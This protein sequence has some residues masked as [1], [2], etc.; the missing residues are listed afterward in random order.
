MA[1]KTVQQWLVGISSGVMLILAGPGSAP[2]QAN[3]TLNGTLLAT[4]SCEAVQSIK[5]QTN[6]GKIRLKAWE[7]YRVIGQNL[8]V[9]ATH[10][11]L[12][13]EGAA[14]SLRWV[15]VSC[16]RLGQPGSEPV[17][18]PGNAPGP[19][20]GNAPGPDPE[21]TP[22]NPPETETLPPVPSLDL[23]EMDTSRRGDFLLALS[24]Q[25]AFCETKPTKIECRDQS[26]DSFE[27]G[28]LALHGLWPQP[29]DNDYCGVSPE[30]EQIDQAKRWDELPPVALSA[31]TRKALAEQMPGYASN[32]HLHEW[33]KHGTCYSNSPEEYF[34]NH[35]C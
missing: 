17:P 16:G 19:D 4:D 26:A 18:D 31:E 30:V 23:P 29:R 22:G 33:Y 8:A 11:L 25:P 10:Y 20:P 1:F 28:N 32:L 13:L 35:W 3:V 14:P 6:P 21:N 2:V 5:K 27:A 34:G 24:W 9:G 12:Q 7:R 15:P